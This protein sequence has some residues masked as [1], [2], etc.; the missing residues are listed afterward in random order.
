MQ[1]L[2][3]FRQTSRIEMLKTFTRCPVCFKD[4]IKSVFQLK[5]VNL[6]PKLTKPQKFSIF[7]EFMHFFPNFR[8]TPEIG[9]LD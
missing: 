3:Q 2:S 6:T 7:K 5:R 8:Q 4:E 1:F 9:I